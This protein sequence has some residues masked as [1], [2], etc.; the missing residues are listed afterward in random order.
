MGVAALVMAGG[1]ATRMRMQFE[2]PLLKIGPRTMLECV[3]NALQNA[4]HVSR[5]IVVVSPRTPKTA[6]KAIRLGVDVMVTPGKGFVRDMQ[7]AVKESKAREVLVV[8]SDLPF[9]TSS[10]VDSVVEEFRRNRKPSLAVVVAAETATKLGMTPTHVIDVER[11]LIPVGL[12]MINGELIQ[13]P[14]LDQSLFVVDS[15]A[16]A[17]NVNTRKELQLARDR[18]RLSSHEQKTKRD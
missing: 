8:C 4:H 14:E 16:L 5:I 6:R 13:E 12:N 2:K 18:A 11:K 7:Y 17:L 3:I 1:K 9:L 10:L 15:E